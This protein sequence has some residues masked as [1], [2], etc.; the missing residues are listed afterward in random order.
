MAEREKVKCW[1]KDDDGV[2]RRVELNVYYPTQEQFEENMRASF[3]NL[4]NDL[5]KE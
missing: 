2:W 3:S 1:I 4:L 5:N